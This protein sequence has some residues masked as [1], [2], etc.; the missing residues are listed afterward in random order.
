MFDLIYLIENKQLK[1]L[2]LFISSTLCCVRARWVIFSKSGK[3]ADIIWRKPQNPVK[4]STLIRIFVCFHILRINI[5]RWINDTK[6][7]FLNTGVLVFCWP[8]S[9]W[10]NLFIVGQL[11]KLGNG[12][13]GGPHRVH[14]SGAVSFKISSLS[15]NQS[16]GFIL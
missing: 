1:F 9:A 2:K 6:R 11:K 13:F 3:P 7:F 15:L 12:G 4:K 5:L 8:K 10:Q 16:T 14:S